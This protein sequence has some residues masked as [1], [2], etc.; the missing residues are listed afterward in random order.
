MRIAIIGPGAVGST[1]AAW[2]K[3]A[4]NAAG[5]VSAL[6]LQ[7]AGV[8]NLEDVADVMRGIVKEVVA[9]GRAEG[10]RLDASLAE[11]VVAQARRAPKDGV[12]SLLADRLA[13]RPMEIDARNGVVVRLGRKHG[14]PTPYNDTLSA[15][16]GA[17]EKGKS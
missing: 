3:L 4:M 7:P 8:A 2:R 17:V 15:C 1:V 9:V 14:I 6:T 5:A 16:L 10:A 11:D 13:G 12:N